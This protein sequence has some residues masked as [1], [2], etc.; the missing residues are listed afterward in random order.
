[1]AGHDNNHPLHQ[2]FSPDSGIGDPF[3]DSEDPIYSETHVAGPNFTL[4]GREIPSA[5]DYR[6]QLVGEDFN[7]DRINIFHVFIPMPLVAQWDPDVTLDTILRATN[8]ELPSLCRWAYTIIEYKIGTMILQS[9][10]NPNF[11][12]SWQTAQHFQVQIVRNI[13]T[14]REGQ[15]DQYTGW[16]PTGF[17]ITI[18][19]LPAYRVPPEEAEA[20]AYI[21]MDTVVQPNGIVAGRTLQAKVPNSVFDCPPHLLKP[22]HITK[23]RRECRLC[24]LFKDV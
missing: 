4:D 1:M 10:S 8:S 2:G 7:L 19:R 3:Y 14:M 23:M 15:P 9:S 6:I 11:R 18:S 16:L 5:M 24:A 21:R 12:L 17:Q 22:W 20:D 13:F